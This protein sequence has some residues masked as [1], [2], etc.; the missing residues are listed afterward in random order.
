MVVDIELL[1]PYYDY[2]WYSEEQITSVFR[3]H[4]RQYRHAWQLDNDLAALSDQWR[5]RESNRANRLYNRGIH[6]R[7]Q[8]LYSLF[9]I[10]EQPEV[11]EA[12]DQR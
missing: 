6:E 8:N 4:G 9:E 3:L 12:E 1:E 7:L 10:D 2:S 11:D 5:L